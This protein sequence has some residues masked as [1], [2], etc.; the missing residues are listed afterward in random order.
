VT[1]IVSSMC[2]ERFYAAPFFV[3]RFFAFILFHLPHDSCQLTALP[4]M[5][6]AG[7]RPGGKLFVNDCS[8][9]RHEAK[10]ALLCT[11]AVVYHVA[12]DCA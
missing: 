6:P 12:D 11:A 4:D 7:L 2:E 5:F 1:I 9:I 8:D 10:K 3:R